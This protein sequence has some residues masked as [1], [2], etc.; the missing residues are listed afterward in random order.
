[1]Q[2]T[3]DD[4]IY[5]LAVPATVALVVCLIRKFWKADFFDRYAAVLAIAPGFAYGYFRLE[6][7]PIDPDTD[8]EFLPYALI[9]AC[10]VGPVA[11]VKGTTWFDRGLLYG[12]AGAALAW[13]VVPQWPDLEPSRLVY[14]LVLGGYMVVVASCFEPA[15]DKLPGPVAPATMAFTCA[16]AAVVAVLSGSARFGQTPGL[17]AGA[18]AGITLAACFDRKH[19]ALRGAA[20]L[21]T[22]LLGGKMLLAR[23]S[24]FDPLPLACYVL[25][26]AAPLLM[27]FAA[28]GPLGKLTGFKRALAQLLPPLIAVGV[29]AGLA[30]SSEYDSLTS[31][32]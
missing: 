25:I 5:G 18:F 29:A 20:P 4:L 23:A 8:W 31:A 15:A 19:N 12:V 14:S 6:L 11:A 13:L 3:R 30:I 21:I 26:P 32:Y 22:G 27:C 1:M 24:S 10:A 2:P 28:F 17:A 7:G 16:G 9:G